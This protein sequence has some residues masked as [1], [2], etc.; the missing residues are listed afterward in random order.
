MVDPTPST[1]ETVGAQALPALVET[2]SVMVEPQ[3]LE[4][5][6]YGPWTAKDIYA[7]AILAAG[8]LAL[9]RPALREAHD[10]VAFDEGRVV[11]LSGGILLASQTVTL[12]R[13]STGSP[14][15]DEVSLRCATPDDRAE[16]ENPWLI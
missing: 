10:L 3:T 14:I 7:S 5:L 11:T 1:F 2:R 13:D 12:T 9:S 15:V 16:E 6:S 8:A 4:R